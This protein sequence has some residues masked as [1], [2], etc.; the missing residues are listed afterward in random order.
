MKLRGLFS[1][2]LAGAVLGAFAQTHVEGV[3]YFS[4]D[5]I[6]NARELLNRNMNN[7]GTD[8]AI[9]NYYLGQISMLEGKKDDAKKY[10]D[11][12]I[13]VNP[14]Y[15]YNYVGL[16]ELLL[17]T[18]PKEAQKLF[19]QAEKFGKKDAALQIAIARAYYNV[20]AV[21]NAKEIS[22]RIE[23]AQRI[24]MAEP[25]IYI[26][27]GDR[28]ADKKEWGNAAA[29]YEMALNFDPNA[30]GAYVKY[31]NVYDY[32]NPNLSIAMLQNLLKQNPAS[33]L[34]QRQLAN[35]YY[36]QERYKEAAQEYGKY[37]Q[38]PNHFKQDEDRYALLLFSDGD[39]KKGYDYASKLL[40]SD[41]K[42]FT[43]QRFQFMNAAQLEEM[44]PVLLGLAESLYANHLA[45]ADNKFAAIDFT[46][47]AD[48]LAKAKKYD[49]ALA[50]LK[51]G[52][53]ELPEQK[54]FIHDAAMVYFDMNQSD[55]AVKEFKR[56]LAGND[57]PSY[58]D[59]YQ[60]ANLA[61]VAAFDASGADKDALLKTA[62]EYSAKAAELNPKSYRPLK[63]GGDVAGMQAGGGS[64]AVKAKAPFYLKAAEVI[65][66]TNT[67]PSASDARDIYKTLGDF[68]V[69]SG[70]NG[71][72]KIYYTK[73]LEV[74][75]EDA[76]VKKIVS[77]L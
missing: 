18:A 4:A 76:A 72:A 12:G 58:N 73:Y 56:Y 48:E 41:P 28:L 67:Q 20:D 51:E 8:K 64:D 19:K 7:A 75:P 50:V 55:K 33:A 60:M 29:Q 74:N 69:L 24:D 30:T 36:N 17:P 16:G 10:F 53:K 39:Y 63:R 25:A 54:S 62:A 47:I 13:A 5:Q 27:E 32:V 9:A 68:Y 22:K 52:E 61:Y 65:S 35:T 21:A 38:N 57:N 66:A 40:Q 34:G 3:E 42:N 45:N 46:L 31:A 26:F 71:N 6:N 2:C 77:T 1:I 15:A 59:A 14:E 23:K 44:Q 70:D 11:A 43:A 37:V 49:D